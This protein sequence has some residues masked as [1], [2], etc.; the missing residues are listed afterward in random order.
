LVT[1]GSVIREIYVRT[2]RHE[3]PQTDTLIAIFCSPH[4]D[5]A[6]IVGS[7]FNPLMHKVDKMVT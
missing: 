2:D 7:R 3:D 4:E 6:R 5:A 1:F